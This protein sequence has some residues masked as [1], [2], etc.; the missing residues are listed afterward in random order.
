YALYHV[1]AFRGLRRAESVGLPWA[2]VDLEEALLT[3]IE[4]LSDDEHDDPDDPKS[5]AGTRTMS[6]D[7]GSVDVI[8]EWQD[9]QEQ[10]RQQS[11]AAW[12]DS[13]RVFTQPDGRPL[14]PGWISE[15]FDALIRKYNAI[16]S[17]YKLGKPI[18]SLARRHRVSEEA[19]KV[20]VNGEPLPPIR[21]HD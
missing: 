21:F 7:P 4:I 3:V 10:E 16:Q 9:R 5:D 19:V 8:I 17:G 2:E 14:R 18:T 6:L 15:R 11:G 13:G 20:A 12:I 1:T